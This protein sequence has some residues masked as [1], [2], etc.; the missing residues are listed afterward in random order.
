[1]KRTRNNNQKKLLQDDE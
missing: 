1:M